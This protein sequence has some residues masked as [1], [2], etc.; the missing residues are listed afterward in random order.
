MIKHVAKLCTKT[1]TA[2]TLS[3][4]LDDDCDVS[5]G[6][7]DVIHTPAAAV[8]GDGQSGDSAVETCA[9]SLNTITKA[10]KRLSSQRR[11]HEDRIVRKRRAH[12]DRTM[13][14]P[15]RIPSDSDGDDND[16]D[17][18]GGDGGGAD[19]EYGDEKVDICG[20]SDDDDDDDDGVEGEDKDNEKEAHLKKTPPLSGI[21]A[22]L[23]KT[24]NGA[25]GSPHMTSQ[26]NPELHAAFEGN[27]FAK[28]RQLSSLDSSWSPSIAP[29][30]IH[31]DLQSEG[32]SNGRS[33]HK[34]GNSRAVSVIP[35]SARRS[36]VHQSPPPAAV[37]ASS[38]AVLTS[39]RFSIE[40]LTSDHAHKQQQ[41]ISG[42]GVFKRR[43]S[44]PPGLNAAASAED[45]G[46]YHF[47]DSSPVG[48]NGHM[49][50]PNEGG[51]GAQRQVGALS[52][53]VTLSPSHHSPPQGV[54][55]NK[56]S[57]ALQSSNGVTTSAALTDRGEHS[58]L[59]P[60]STSPS[61]NCDESAM[62]RR[63][64]SSSSLSPSSAG[65]ATSTDVQ[66]AKDSFNNNNNSSA[67]SSKH[68]GNGINEKNSLSSF[69]AAAKRAN[70]ARPSSFLISDI[71]GVKESHDH[72]H[73]S[74]DDDED[75]NIISGSKPPSSTLKSPS[76]RHVHRDSD[77][78]NIRNQIGLYTHHHHHNHHP[79]HP[80]LQHHPYSQH[81]Q[82]PPP[83]LHQTHN[84]N[85]PHH[86]HPHHPHPYSL[87]N[88]H[89]NNATSNMAASLALGAPYSSFPGLNPGHP[90]LSSGYQRA[91]EDDHR[92]PHHPGTDP[93]H[94]PL[95]S[96]FDDEM[97][98]EEDDDNEDE[99]G[100]DGRDNDSTS[101]GESRVNGTSVLFKLKSP[102]SR[103]CLS[104]VG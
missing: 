69:A 48:E 81:Q 59:S 23:S 7:A 38:A 20:N 70:T 88:S 72:H 12:F 6:T 29:I 101:E 86:H 25:S 96:S 8:L 63:K 11:N 65:A 13:T 102:Q 71:L 32:L 16:G 40:S 97:M 33:G 52:E 31:T 98:R 15:H 83:P 17:E 2:N 92:S 93:T 39:N 60:A 64:P 100:E 104:N 68:D 85:H 5:T 10:R 103:V 54:G 79:H 76:A 84:N 57:A 55:Q 77:H 91:G 22:S 27:S 21:C 26:Q 61:P 56:L 44:P 82:P 24:T 99:D 73:N 89:H 3:E 58:V 18:N 66:N 78:D 28:I 75:N 1:T 36:H 4:M 53:R 62:K 95:D 34:T 9:T 45:S 43:F 94:G 80:R 47:P 67:R 37:S 87:Y 42:G 90:A 50:S 19:D 30:G 49:F 35:T 51:E 46:G 14:N 74:D 41:P